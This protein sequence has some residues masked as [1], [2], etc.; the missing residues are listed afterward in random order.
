MELR[1]LT[2]LDVVQPQVV[3]GMQIVERA[4]GL[5][6][7]HAFDQ[8]EVRQAS[9]EILERLGVAETDHLAPRVLSREIM[10]LA[11]IA[12]RPNGGNK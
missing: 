4:F 6:E 1:A 5:L 12:G 8:G 11:G 2:Y 9:A 3:P 10:V 7:L